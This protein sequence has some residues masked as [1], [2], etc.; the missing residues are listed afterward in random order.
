[1][2]K[3]RYEAGIQLAAK[4]EKYRSTNA[5]VLAIPKGGVPVGFELAKA[6]GLP[7]EIAP[8]KKIVHPF[9]PEY[10]IGSVF[11]NG[12]AINKEV[13]DVSM[14]YIHKEADLLLQELR[15]EL[16]RYIGDHNPINLK[17]KTVIIA[18]DGVATGF[19]ILAAIDAVRR[20][21]PKRIVA[22]IPVAPSFIVDKL[23]NVADEFV[24]LIKPD[25]FLAVG[26]FYEDFPEMT[27][28]D[29]IKCL[30]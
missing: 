1:M 26:Q 25:Y 22:A 12:T 19:T 11:I 27:D 5:V 24:C 28:G 2:F 9:N 18:D 10:Y 17:N 6:L 21:Q 4:L 15:K 20:E 3:T 7:L 16:K 13:M 14:D 8:Y 30:T 23:L 29:V